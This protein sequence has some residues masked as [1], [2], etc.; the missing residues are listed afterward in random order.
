MERHR[1]RYEFNND[2]RDE[3][4]SAGLVISGT[5]PDGGLVEIGELRDHAWMVGSQ[6]HPEFRSR[7][8][9]PHPLFAGFVGAAVQRSQKRRTP[10]VTTDPHS[11][12]PAPSTRARV[13]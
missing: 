10:S 4:A 12:H 6:F 13:R 5:S 9:R 1:H 3:L 2:Y 8:G 7:P 11:R